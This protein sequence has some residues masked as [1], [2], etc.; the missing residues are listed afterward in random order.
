ML[1]H[2][3]T[4]YY[5]QDLANSAYSNELQVTNLKLRSAQVGVQGM[6]EELTGFWIK[7]G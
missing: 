5:S 2:R 1:Y 7:D 6:T 3:H 4:K